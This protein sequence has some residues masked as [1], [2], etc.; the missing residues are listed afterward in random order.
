V[1]GN[2]ND[3]HGDTHGDNEL[4]NEDCQ[5]RVR[6][7]HGS[8][9]DIDNDNDMHGDMHGDMHVNISG[10]YKVRRAEFHR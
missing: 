8:N 1:L 10:S 7:V 4:L 5:C 6:L 9:N 3:M 2:G